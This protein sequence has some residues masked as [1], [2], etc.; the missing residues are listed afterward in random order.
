M[1][2]AKRRW[3][4]VAYLVLFIMGGAATWLA[5]VWLKTQGPIAETQQGPIAE[6]QR[7]P[8]ALSSGGGGFV[9]RIDTQ[10]EQV[11]LCVIE[12]S[13]SETP[14]PGLMTRHTPKCSPWG[15]AAEH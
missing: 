14:S 10:T 12:G 4:I 15:P 1:G 11:S 6:T 2:V 5:L 7:G 9:W 8:Y 3:L 13:A